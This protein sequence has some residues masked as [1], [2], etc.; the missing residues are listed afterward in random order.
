MQNEADRNFVKKKLKEGIERLERCQSPGMSAELASRVEQ[1][2]RYV[3][4]FLTTNHLI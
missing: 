2:L 1:L 3:H 4:I